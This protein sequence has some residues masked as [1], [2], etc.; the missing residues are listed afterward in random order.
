MMGADGKPST[1]YP[2]KDG[3]FEVAVPAALL[4]DQPKTLTLKWIDFYRR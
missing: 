2:L 4:R 3:Y 1:D